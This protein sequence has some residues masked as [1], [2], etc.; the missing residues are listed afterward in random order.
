MAIPIQLIF[1]RLQDLSRK[2]KAGYMSSEEFNRDF[3][4][5]Q[6]DLFEFYFQ[7]YE[8]TQ[9]IVDSQLPFLKEVNLPITAGYCDFPA[10]YRHRVE[11]AYFYLKNADTCKAGEPASDE[12]PMY[13]LNANE[14]RETQ[15]SAIR[16][17]SLADKNLYHLFINGKIKVLPTTLIGLIKFK[18]FIAPPAAFYAVTLDVTNDQENF[19]PALSINPIWNMQDEQNLVDL[20]LFYKGIE[21]RESALIQWVAQRK[22]LINTGN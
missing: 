13:Y 4:Q 17:P 8:R 19:D 11:V 6:T 10:D 7:Q 22:Q 2:D 16:R 18:Y 20:L 21:T 9:S 1:E 14:E 5:A 12:I 15:A 3:A